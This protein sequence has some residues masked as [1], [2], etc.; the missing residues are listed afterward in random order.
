VADAP[1]LAGV[2]DA[3]LFASAVLRPQT[4]LFGDDAYP[5]IW[6]PTG[7]GCWVGVLRQVREVYDNLISIVTDTP[8]PVTR[9]TT[10]DFGAS[11]AS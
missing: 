11:P 8:I 5:F 3:G 10:A 1:V 9:L 6:V 4:S 2:G 7:G